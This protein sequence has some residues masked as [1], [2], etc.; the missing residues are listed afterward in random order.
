MEE[1]QGGGMEQQQRDFSAFISYKRGGKDEYWAQWLQKKLETYRIPKELRTPE[2]GLSAGRFRIFRDKSDLGSHADLKEGLARSLSAS[3]FLI[4]ICSPR[5]AASSYVDAEVRFFRQQGRADHI[6]PFIIEGLPE[7]PPHAPPEQCCYPPS[8]PASALGITLDEG[9]REEALLKTVARLLGVDFP[10]LYQRHLRVQRRFVL[11]VASGLACTLALVAG[12]AVWALRAER[13]A[14]AQRREAEGLI[15]F[16]TIDLHAESAKYMP[17]RAQRKIVEKV[18][19]YYDRWNVQNPQALLNR[20]EH[21]QNEAYHLSMRDRWEEAEAVMRDIIALLER[22]RVSMPENTRV[23]LDQCA[24]WHTLARVLAANQ[25]EMKGVDEAVVRA[26]RVA[27]EFAAQ[28]ADKDMAT[29]VLAVNTDRASNYYAARGHQAEAERLGRQSVELITPLWEKEPGDTGFSRQYMSSLSSACDALL[30]RAAYK[31]PLC[32]RLQDWLRSEIAADPQDVEK[33][34]ILART[35]VRIARMVLSA[36]GK[37]EKYEAMLREALAT[38]RG[39]V[40][41]DAEESAAAKWYAEGIIVQFNLRVREHMEG[42][43]PM[44]AEDYLPLAEAEKMVR[45]AAGEQVDHPECREML[46]MLRDMQY[47]TF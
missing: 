29:L 20:V 4:V 17:M 36:G 25:R 9:S 39:I 19:S 35:Q 2:A 38:L 32:L 31:D 42:G 40:E 8:L 14:T 24:A 7:P 13:Q 12:L 15:S 46:T 3:R 28:T 16:L 33:P 22:L 43:R 44:R 6:I 10:H 21:L 5:G 18:Q 34:Q 1:K 47:L 27:R 26:D 30:L 23:V 11:R 41:K 37:D 45:A